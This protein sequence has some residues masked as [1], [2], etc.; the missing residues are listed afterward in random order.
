MSRREETGCHGSSSARRSAAV[1]RHSGGLIG[2]FLDDPVTRVYSSPWWGFHDDRRTPAVSIA[3]RIP[4]RRSILPNAVESDMLGDLARRDQVEDLPE[5]VAPTFHR[6]AARAQSRLP[7]FDGD[8]VV[9]YDQADPVGSAA[10]IRDRTPEANAVAFD[11]GHTLFNPSSR[12]EHL[13]TLLAAIEDGPD[14]LA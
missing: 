12:E 14:A 7:P 11:G 9:F 13:D 6:E 10:A 5:R 3:M 1:R 8:A 2:A 4:T